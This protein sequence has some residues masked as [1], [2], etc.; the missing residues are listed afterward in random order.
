MNHRE[1][2]TIPDMY[3]FYNVYKKYKAFENPC[4]KQNPCNPYEETVNSI[5][6]TGVYIVERKHS[7]LYGLG[8]LC[9]YTDKA[10]LKI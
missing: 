9:D 3:I 2:S 1:H 7:Y 6:N 8:R 4:F 5:L 10:K